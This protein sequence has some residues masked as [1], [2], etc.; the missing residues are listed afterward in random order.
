[1]PLKR[2]DVIPMCVGPVQPHPQTDL[3]LPG[4]DE[5][6]VRRAGVLE[7]EEVCAGASLGTPGVQQ[8]AGK[9]LEERHSSHQVTILQHSTP[10]HYT[11]LA[12]DWS[13][14]LAV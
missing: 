4:W 11:L 8:A 2:N 13:L 7:L 12:E 1:M 5:S 14:A 10:S 9:W 3:P 6:Q